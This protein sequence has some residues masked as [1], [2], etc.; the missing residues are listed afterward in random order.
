[1]PDS[2]PSDRTPAERQADHAELARLSDTLV[3]ALVQKLNGSGLGELEVREG[4]WKIRLRRPSG[5]AAH[6]RRERQRP[7]ISARPHAPAAVPR[8]PTREAVTA[9]AVGVFRATATVGTKL[10]TGDR[11]GVVDLLGIP[12]DVVSPIDGILVDILVD[13]GDAVEYGEEVAVVQEP[14]PPPEVAASEEASLGEAGSGG[15]AAAGEGKA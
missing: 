3:P 9:P 11:V 14:A 7:A 1:M 4:P 5:A 15:D 2:R 6:A 8:D 12:Q 13:T 10:R